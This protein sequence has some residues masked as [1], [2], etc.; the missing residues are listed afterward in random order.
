MRRVLTVL[1]VL[2]LTFPAASASAQGRNQRETQTEKT[3][4]TVTIGADGEIDVSN[5]AGDIMVTRGGGTS[6]A[7]EIVKTAR[8][9]SVD[10]AKALLGLVTVDIAERGPRVEIRT[11]Y[12]GREEMRGRGR[13]NFNVDV[14][15]TIAA[16]QNTRIIA[17]SISGNINVRDISGALTLDSVSGTVKLANAGRMAN[18]KTISGNVE[19]IDSRVD[20][21]L[22]AGTISG[23]VKLQKVSARQLSLSS[24]SGS[25]WLQD[26][27][28]ERIEGQAISGDIQFTGDFEPNGRYEFTSH[29]GS[30]RLA[31]GDK[32]GFQVEAT[33]FS[34]DIK[35]DLPITLEGGQTTMRRAKAL[36]GK[37]GDGSAF[38]DLTSFSGSILITKR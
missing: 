36:R 16:P 9:E 38:L 13:R 2:A 7:I 21:A 24:V 6:A 1:A 11:R 33:S 10:E 19:V 29:S 15:F 25:V 5:I 35:S 4:R 32:T 12:P 31:V 34:G 14:A 26:V 17:R 22:A 23:T 30:V 18:A 8:A 37:H 27:T 20:G 28:C 3:T